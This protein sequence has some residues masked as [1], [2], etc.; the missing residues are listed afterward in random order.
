M[1]AVIF[2]AITDQLDDDYAKTAERMRGLA[3][4]EYGCSKFNA[5]HEDGQ[6]IAISYWER[7]EQILAWKKHAEHLQA[8]NIGRDH[9]YKSY[10]V[11]VMK[12]VRSYSFEC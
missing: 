5:C 11:E 9:W 6:E 12:M 3:F 4:S 8:Q 2:T 7:E 10:T 1:Y